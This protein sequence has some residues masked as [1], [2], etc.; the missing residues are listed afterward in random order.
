M[1]WKTRFYDNE[2]DNYQI[3]INCIGMKSI[4]EL[5]TNLAFITLKE[6]LLWNY[7]ENANSLIMD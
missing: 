4:N 5:E 7:K 1:I 3:I 2:T 6:R